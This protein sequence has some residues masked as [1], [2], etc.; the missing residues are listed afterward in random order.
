[1]KRALSEAHE[2]NDRNDWE[3]T[4]SKGGFP[5]Y[6]LAFRGGII[7]ARD[8]IRDRGLSVSDG[9]KRIAISRIDE[10]RQGYEWNSQVAIRHSL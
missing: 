9:F 7:H 3:S 4:E 8:S 5:I 6:V 10:E 1:M 2:I